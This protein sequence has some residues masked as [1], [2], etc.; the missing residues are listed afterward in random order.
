MSD[1]EYAIKVE[2]VSKS[3]KLPHEK[4][5]SIKGTLINFNKAWLRE[6]AGSKRYILRSEKRRVLWYCWP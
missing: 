5:T 6:A 1:D 3:F 2:N 4:Q